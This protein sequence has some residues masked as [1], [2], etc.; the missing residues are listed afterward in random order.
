[1]LLFAVCV[2]LFSAP[3][4]LGRQKQ[5]AEWG[6]DEVT[7]KFCTQDQREMSTSPPYYGTV[8]TTPSFTICQG[9]SFLVPVDFRFSNFASW[10][11]TAAR[12]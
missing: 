1:M 7:T 2:S 4:S 6:Q 8:T 11:V 10:S 12:F 9:F 3:V 5:K